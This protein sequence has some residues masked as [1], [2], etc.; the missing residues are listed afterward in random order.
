MERVRFISLFEKFRNFSFLSQEETKVKN[1]LIKEEE[2]EEEKELL[3]EEVTIQ[4]EKIW[5]LKGIS[6]FMNTI[7]PDEIS[8]KNN[9]KKISDNYCGFF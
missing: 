1:E 6:T 9:I 2:D 3:F 5:M 7:N 8:K 4:Q